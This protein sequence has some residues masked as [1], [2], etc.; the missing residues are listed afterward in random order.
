MLGTQG[1]TAGPQSLLCGLTEAVSPL[2][3]SVF[4][5]LNWE[6]GYLPCKVT[7][8]VSWDGGIP[9]GT[10][11]APRGAL[12]VW[13]V[14]ASG[15]GQGL[16]ALGMAWL[17]LV[18]PAW[19]VPS[20]ASSP[21]PPL[22]LAQL[23]GCLLQAVF[24]NAQLGWTGSLALGGPHCVSPRGL[25]SCLLLGSYASSLTSSSPSS[26]VVF[27]KPLS[28]Q[29]A[30]LPSSCPQLLSNIQTAWPGLRGRQVGPPP[31]APA[32]P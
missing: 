9:P 13:G 22:W 25:W 11:L 7:G 3:T 1:L 16:S 26:R 29:D 24:P 21:L 6:Q 27:E 10:A 17:W 8:R 23:W 20:R 5:S 30:A 32:Q 2:W 14:G 28:S 18:P 4:S 31:P 12:S 19:L 15:G